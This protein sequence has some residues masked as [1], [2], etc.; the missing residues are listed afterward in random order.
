MGD[1]SHASHASKT[2]EVPTVVMHRKRQD[3]CLVASAPKS[4]S[5]KVFRHITSLDHGRLGFTAGPAALFLLKVAALEIVRRVSRAKCPFA[6]FSLQTL[7]ILC[8]PP[9]KWIERWPVF[10]GLVKGMQTLSR[11]LLFLSIATVFSD[12]SECSKETSEETTGSQQYLEPQSEE[13][14]LDTRTN[15]ES[16]T[17][18]SMPSES[19]L[20]QLHRELEKQGITLP[21]R[22][23]TAANGDF[24][25]LLSSIKKTIRWRETYRILSAQEL[26]VWSHLVF[27]HGCDAK[28]RPCLIIRLGLACSSLA[29][30]DRPRFAQAVVSQVEHGV[31]HLVNIEDPQITVLMDCE[32]LSPLRFP[33]Q[34]MRSCLA[35]MQNHYPNRL[36]CFFVIR[37]PPVVRVIA[38]TFIQVLK[39][40]TRKK[41]RIEGDTYQKVLSEFL[42]TLPAF[43]GG[44]CTCFKCVNLGSRDIWRQT[45]RETDKRRLVVDSSN[46]E[47]LSSAVDAYP[48]DFDMNG[49][50]DQ[51][52]R[53]AIVA[54]LMLFIFSAFIGGL[55]D[56]DGL[57][58]LS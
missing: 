36:A 47:D 10:K 33:M 8:Y 42:Q 31:L 22:F 2:L 11:P 21:E 56:P 14:T 27:W 55:Y 39:P 5:R 53:T 32:G 24:S 34:M 38:Q 7:Q 20:I 57:P 17:P 18:Q 40:V 15:D 29:S 46:H 4:F 41:L 3:R 28:L 6:W 54:I 12:Q 43:L 23:Y 48:V 9:F 58:M 19:W 44:S 26:E 35:L 45:G 37:L 13:S 49:N 30:H 52:L 50:W 51:V 25:C 16:E 1:P